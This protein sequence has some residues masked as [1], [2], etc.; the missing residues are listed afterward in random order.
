MISTGHICLIL[1]IKLLIS[2]DLSAISIKE[3]LN[4]ES[5]LLS[6]GCGVFVCR[7]NKD[8]MLLGWANV[9]FLSKNLPVLSKDITRY[10]KM[11]YLLFVYNIVY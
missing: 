8:N 9:L 4:S 6:S 5:I 11:E 3:R 7:L 1:E 10:P 2:R